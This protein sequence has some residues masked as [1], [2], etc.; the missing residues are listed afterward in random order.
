MAIESGF[1][2]CYNFPVLFLFS[3]CPHAAYKEESQS[4]LRGTSELPERAY[5]LTIA[6]V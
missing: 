2:G 1:N 4:Y 3:S 5:R 6:L